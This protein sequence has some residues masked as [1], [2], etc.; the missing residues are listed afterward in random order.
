MNNIVSYAKEHMESFDVRPLNRVD[1]LILSELSYFQLPQELS[2]ARGW[3]GV[4]L[5]ELFRA[6]CFEQMFD[7]VWDGESCR[8]LLTA[9]SAS[10]RFRDI[11]VMGY[12]EQS[13]VADEKQFAAVTFR[14][15]K[16][17]FYVAFRGTDATPVGW[18]EDFNMAFQ[19]PVPSQ[20]AAAAYLNEA[21]F[22][23][24][25]RLL[26]GGHS[27]GGN[28]AVYA[29][30]NCGKRARKR[31]EKI[32]SHDGPGF[33]QEVL[34]SDLFQAV[35]TRIEKTVPQSSLIGMLFENQED[36]TIV[37]SR[38]IGLL[39]HDPY[40]WVVEDGD[41][42]YPDRLTADAR[43]LDRTLNQ[44]IRSLSQED[45]ERFVDGLYD[46]IEENGIK[47]FTEIRDD[48]RKNIPALVHSVT[49]MDEDT[50]E[51]MQRSLKDLAA[52]SFQNITGIFRGKRGEETGVRRGAEKITEHERKQESKQGDK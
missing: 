3:R 12:R 43:Y 47:S 1:S 49:H 30:A 50:K 19:Y 16:R 38:G 35:L 17:L 46:L 6:E 39:Q 2:K 52:M 11:H 14:L 28:L 15:S 23:C 29:A 9:L 26:V 13:N 37:K 32:Y 24:R 10:P 25:G 4:R 44:W 34:E 22:H 31:I 21:A 42:T 48:W 18:K 41:F 40:S 20:E 36:F 45:R 7:G 8:Q 51:F 5:A 27:K 33:A